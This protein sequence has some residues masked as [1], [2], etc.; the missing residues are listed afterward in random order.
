MK[1]NAITHP[2][3]GAETQPPL[4]IAHGLFGS[5][6]NWNSVARRLTR[7][8]RVVALDMRNHGDSPH[9]PENGYPDMAADLVEA[10]AEHAGAE[11]D[12]LGHSMGG[13]AAMLLALTGDAPLRRLVIADIAP[14]AYT[15]SHLPYIE[16]MQAV[17]LSHVERRS[18]VE[19]QLAEAVPDRGLRA[20]L[21]HSLER[22]QGGLRWRLNLDALARAMPDLT[23]WPEPSGRYEGPT[24]FLRGSASDY[25]GPAHHARI[26]ELFPNAEIETLE[27]LG[28]WLHAQDPERFAEAVARFLDA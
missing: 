4:L 2:A 7:G 14:V 23:G 26:R 12:L 21:L 15:H 24:L 28:H 13:K 8:R 16:A 27:G 10:I 5:A 20:F 17:D 25:A 3:E 1:L 6:R 18:D 11:A 9:V 22:T 19:R